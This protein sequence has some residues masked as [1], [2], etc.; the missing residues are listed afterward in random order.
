MSDLRDLTIEML[1]QRL[2]D[3]GCS[4]IVAATTV[5]EAFCLGIIKANQDVRPARDRS[6]YISP[7]DETFVYVIGRQNERPLKIGVSANPDGRAFDLSVAHP[8]KLAVLYRIAAKT[9]AQAMQWEKTA[10]M[11]LAECRLDGEWFDVGLPE[12]IAAI[13]EAAHG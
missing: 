4:P 7:D 9:R 2:I 12:A 5:T 3:A 6:S 10:H 13:C 8:L 11:K 1:V